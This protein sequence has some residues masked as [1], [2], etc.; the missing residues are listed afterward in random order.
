M[1]GKT[2][3][4]TMTFHF[5]KTLFAFIALSFLLPFSTLAATLDASPTSVTVSS[6]TLVTETIFVSSNDQATN[7]ISGTVS[8]PTDLLQVVSVS[9]A[10]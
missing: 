6:G 2:Q 1:V 8:F 7:A 9:K 4:D 10:N 5:R 3:K